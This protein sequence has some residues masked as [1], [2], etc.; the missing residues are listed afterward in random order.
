M[1]IRNPIGPYKKKEPLD[2]KAKRL[3]IEEL[4]KFPE[5]L[6]RLLSFADSVKYEEKTLR[7]VW[8]V[9][10]VVHHLADSH[11]N[12]FIRMKLAL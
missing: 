12:A 5:D 2:E 1:D 3:L 6:K 9:K 11:M 8:T 4:E 10:Q 7:G